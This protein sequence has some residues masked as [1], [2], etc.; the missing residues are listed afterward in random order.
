MIHLKK[1]RKGFSLITTVFVILFIGAIGAGILSLSGKMVG[2]TIVQ[3]KKEQSILYAKSYT[4]MAIMA[5]T[6]NNCVNTIDSIEGAGTRNR[7]DIHIDIRYVGNDINGV[8][9]CA[10]ANSIG[11]PVGHPESKGN[12]ILVDTV[13][14]YVNDLS[15]SNKTIRYYRRTIQKL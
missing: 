7:Y 10:G 13:V 14:T 3:Y 4:E 12:T 15:Q 2:E 11:G 6:A 9:G 8:A 5:A 1:N